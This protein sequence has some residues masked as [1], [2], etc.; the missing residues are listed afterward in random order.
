MMATVGAATERA[1]GMR[2]DFILGKPETGLMGRQ[3]RGAATWKPGL[4]V[5]VCLALGKGATVK[6][7]ST[8]QER[9]CR[10]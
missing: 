9:G 4:Q 8:V 5:S 1:L 6:E 10:S 2:E 3:R 7:R